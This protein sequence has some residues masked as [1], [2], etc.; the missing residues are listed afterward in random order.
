MPADD[1]TYRM[2]RLLGNMDNKAAGIQLKTD[3]RTIV[4]QAHRHLCA[5]DNLEHKEA[6]AARKKL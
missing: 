1:E 3:F 5:L 2:L 6:K 4:E